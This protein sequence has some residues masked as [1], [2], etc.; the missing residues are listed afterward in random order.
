MIRH[1][2]LKLTRNASAAE[3]IEM[4]VIKSNNRFFNEASKAVGGRHIVFALFVALVGRAYSFK[5]YVENYRIAISISMKELN[6][7]YIMSRRMMSMIYNIYRGAV[8]EKYN[9]E[10]K[11]EQSVDTAARRQ[12]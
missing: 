11:C 10:V 7:S 1:S 3:R 4:N 6:L 8:Y 2:R 12:T 9:D 5:K